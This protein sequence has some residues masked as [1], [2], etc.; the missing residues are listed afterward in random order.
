MAGLQFGFGSV[1]PAPRMHIAA[2]DL[3]RNQRGGAVE[4]APCDPQGIAQQESQKATLRRAGVFEATNHDASSVTRSV[5]GSRA[6]WW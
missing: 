6:G 5:R 4:P 2:T 1:L 3:Q